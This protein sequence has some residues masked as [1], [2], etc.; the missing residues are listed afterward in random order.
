MASAEGPARCARPPARLMG[1]GC[2][3]WPMR[4]GPGAPLWEAAGA[5]RQEVNLH[6]AFFARRRDLARH[7]AHGTSTRGGTFYPLGT[8]PRARAV[9]KCCGFRLCA[10]MSACGLAF[11]YVR[12]EVGP[13]SLRLAKCQLS[14]FLLAQVGR[15]HMRPKLVPKSPQKWV[16][17]SMLG[18]PRAMICGFLPGLGQIHWST[19]CQAWP[20]A[21]AR[22]WFGIGRA[23]P[24]LVTHASVTLS[25]LY[26]SLFLFLDVYVYICI[27]TYIC[28]SRYL[29]LCLHPVSMPMPMSL[30]MHTPIPDITYIYV[31]IFM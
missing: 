20:D 25:F 28:I 11:R 5:S 15:G 1:C 23:R 21:R 2:P 27:C 14:L 18:R 10:R 30:Q 7:D 3:G 16:K 29:H 6:A 26:L 22:C 8:A 9:R 19:S 13:S 12:A 4:G 17:F 24:T 31:D